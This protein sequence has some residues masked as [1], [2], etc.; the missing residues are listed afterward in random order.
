[1]GWFWI[2][3]G[4]W[5]WDVFGTHFNSFWN[6]FGIVLKHFQDLFMIQHRFSW[7]QSLQP[8]TESGPASTLAQTKIEAATTRESHAA[9][10]LGGQTTVVNLQCRVSTLGGYFELSRTEKMKLNETPH[11]I[12]MMNIYSEGPRCLQDTPKTQYN[13]HGAPRMRAPRPARRYTC[14]I[15]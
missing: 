9:G 7:H 10:Q 15:Q 3:F 12:N 2:C 1:M 14:E 5:I 6:V 4:A 11:K 8:K 13:A